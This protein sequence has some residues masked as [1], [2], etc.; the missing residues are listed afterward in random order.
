MEWLKKVSAAWNWGRD[1]GK[2]AIVG[3]LGIIIG[4]LLTWKRV[5]GESIILRDTLY[6]QQDNPK[7]IVASEHDTVK[8]LT[9]VHDTVSGKSADIELK[10]LS[11]K[12]IPLGA[13]FAAAGLLGISLG[14]TEQDTFKLPPKSLLDDDYLSWGGKT[15]FAL[16]LP[17]GF[18]AGFRLYLSYDKWEIFLGPSVMYT[19]KILWQLWA[20][21]SVK[22]L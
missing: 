9:H 12:E 5:P 15:E 21:L 2:Y 19:Y 11:G 22:I 18:L 6:I 1:A 13:A 17:T 3:I 14:V 16:S 20:G 4:V 8:I 7:Y 10:F